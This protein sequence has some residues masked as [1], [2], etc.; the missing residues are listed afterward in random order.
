MEKSRGHDGCDSHPD[1]AATRTDF[2][3]GRSVSAMPRSTGR[4]SRVHEAER[5]GERSRCSIAILALH[6]DVDERLAR[7]LGIAAADGKPGRVEGR[8]LHLVVVMVDVCD[9]VVNRLG[10]A[11]LD[12]FATRIAEFAEDAQCRTLDVEQVKPLPRE[13]LV[14]IAVE[15]SSCCAELLDEVP[16]VDGL[17]HLAIDAA[18]DFGREG[19]DEIVISIAEQGNLESRSLAKQLVD[20]TRGAMQ[21][22]RT[23][24]IGHRA[25]ADRVERVA[26]AIVERDGRDPHHA[27]RHGDR[28]L[29]RILLGAA[30]RSRLDGR[31]RDTIQTHADAARLCGGSY[32]VINASSMSAL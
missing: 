19:V 29:R 17:K 16:E 7:R 8:V 24:V 12:A 15:E 31:Q 13:T 23:A 11:E 26:V 30:R 21:Q 9:R 32:A 22:A 3:S 18:S 6:P 25:V 1:H 27:P 2:R 10:F 5:C 14:V 28:P 20:V 4:S